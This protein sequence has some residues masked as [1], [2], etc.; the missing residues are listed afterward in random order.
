MIFM[1]LLIVVH[2]SMLEAYL[3]FHKVWH[4]GLIS[5][6]RQTWKT[7]KKQSFLDTQGKPGKRKEF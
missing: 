1:L 5:G 7:W 3:A 6:L 2:C 4:E